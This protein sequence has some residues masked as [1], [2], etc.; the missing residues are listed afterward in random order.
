MMVGGSGIGESEGFFF[1]FGGLAGKGV[2]VVGAGSGLKEFFFLKTGL[3][4]F[5]GRY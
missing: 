5:L 1:F 2:K 4:E 3:K